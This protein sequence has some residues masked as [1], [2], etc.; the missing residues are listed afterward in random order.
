MQQHGLVVLVQGG[1]SELDQALLRTRL[2][3]SHLDHLA[4]D[5]QL[6]TGA[7]WPGPAALIEA[8]AD[9]AASRLEFGLN[10][11]P[12]RHSSGVPAAGSQSTK[13][14]VARRRLIEVE[15]LRI[16]LGCER[17]G[18]LP[19][20]AQPPGTERLPHCKIF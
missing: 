11:E 18:P 8:S 9:E 6:V 15:R 4:L 12:H 5:A 17:E 20:D 19:V 14:R 16:E 10:Q 7:H 13:N 3:R 2:R 1:R